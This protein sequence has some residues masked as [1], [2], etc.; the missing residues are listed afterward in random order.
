MPTL[1]IILVLIL[2]CNKLFINSGVVCNFI[3]Y[4]YITAQGRELFQISPK[5]LVPLPKVLFVYFLIFF[6]NK[7]LCF[8]FLIF[9]MLF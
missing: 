8:M 1:K 7:V 2:S 9:P 3:E 6:L 5:S 4:I